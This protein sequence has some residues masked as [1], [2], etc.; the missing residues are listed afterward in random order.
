MCWVT[1]EFWGAGGWVLGI[2]ARGPTEHHPTWTW[3]SLSEPWGCR[4]DGLAAQGWQVGLRLPS[5][6]SSLVGLAQ[7]LYNSSSESEAQG[8]THTHTPS[9]MLTPNPDTSTGWKP[10]G[11]GLGEETG[12][13]RTASP[14]EG[15]GSLG[16][17]LRG[18]LQHVGGL[19]V[20]RV[21]EQPQDEDVGQRL[22]LVLQLLRAQQAPWGRVKHLVLVSGDPG[23]RR[24]LLVPRTLGFPGDLP[25]QPWPAGLAPLRP[26][27][28]TFGSPPSECLSPSS[29]APTRPH[30]W[31]GRWTRGLHP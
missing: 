6:G 31:R 18:R 1:P 10:S 24:G 22:A 4:G 3:P 2:P 23:G 17:S 15:D 9:N 20:I 29:P 19:P 21:L 25:P 27:L 28:T 14:R 11:H 13:G 12:A 26:L 5:S 16:H 30:P 8:N 7:G